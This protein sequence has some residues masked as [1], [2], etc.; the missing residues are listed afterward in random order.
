MHDAVLFGYTRGSGGKGKAT[1]ILVRCVH[2]RRA[3]SHWLESDAGWHQKTKR[4]E[5]NLRCTVC[6][7]MLVEM[8]YALSTLPAVVCLRKRY[9]QLLLSLGV[10][11]R[12]ARI[13]DDQCGSDVRC[14][15]FSVSFSSFLK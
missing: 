8:R 6:V 11:F 3:S 13:V 1:H 9:R 4:W 2:L 14:H 5:K 12:C 7:C 10:R 15:H